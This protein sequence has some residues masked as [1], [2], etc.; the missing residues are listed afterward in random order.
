MDL[1]FAVRQPLSA[2]TCE[3]P[4]TILSLPP[5]PL[6]PPQATRFMTTR[7]AAT[8]ATVSLFS[9]V[10]SSSPFATCPFTGRDAGSPER[11]PVDDDRADPLHPQA[12]RLARGGGP[13]AVMP[14]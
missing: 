5:P 12:G 11:D 10:L 14:V 1:V 3:K 13:P 9:T 2:P 4:I 7:P 6:L 8:A